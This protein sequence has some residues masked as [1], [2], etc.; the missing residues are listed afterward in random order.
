MESMLNAIITMEVKEGPVLFRITAKV[1]VQALR[2]GN[3][4]KGNACKDKSFKD[5]VCRDTAC[6]GNSSYVKASR[7]YASMG[8]AC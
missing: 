2:K 4:C 8:K 6:K 3:V 7:Y 5:D 1:M